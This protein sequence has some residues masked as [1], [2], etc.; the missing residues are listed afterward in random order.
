MAMTFGAAPGGDSPMLLQQG[1]DP[2]K[3]ML[4]QL[5]A[6]NRDMPPART[7]YGAT[8]Q[9]LASALS[10][11]TGG[12]A[13]HRDSAEQEEAGNIVA[14][15]MKG[16]APKEKPGLF[17][18][19]GNSLGLGD[20]AKPAAAAMPA[21]APRANQLASLIAEGGQP[22][23]TPAVGMP[24]S[25][26]P[27]SG[28]T[29]PAA[30]VSPASAPA[31]ARP[32]SQKELLAQALNSSNKYVK[33]WAM[34]RALAEADAQTKRD[35]E[36]DKE[37]A[38][39]GLRRIANADGTF[40]VSPVSGYGQGRGQVQADEYT[41]Q[42]P[43]YLARRQGEADQDIRNKP[44]QAAATITAETPA[45]VAQETAL[46][47]V[48]VGRAGAT[49]AAQEKAALPFVE[50]KATAQAKG[51]TTGTLQ[52]QTAAITP[53]VA[54]RV[55]AGITTMGGAGTAATAGGTQAVTGNQNA[56]S[57]ANVLRDEFDAKSK[58]FRTASDAYNKIRVSAEQPSAAG[59]IALLTGFMRLQDPGS[60]VREGE[61][62]T[63]SNAGS[64]DEKVRNIY[65]KIV[66]GQRLTVEQ[67]NDFL[68][69]SGNA[70]GAY[71]KGFDNL[72]TQYTDLATR[73]NLKPADVVSDYSKGIDLTPVK[74]PARIPVGD[75]PTPPP[76]TLPGQKGA[77]PAPQFTPEQIQAEIARRGLK[78]Q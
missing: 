65:N 38:T 52:A 70:F 60:T 73:N 1:P 11:L 47:P 15:L 37:F 62:A 66:S 29:M 67:R 41:A 54:A 58:D 40:S 10:G 71:K 75:V 45:K 34:N 50:P 30:P 49:T 21:P 28:V 16:E 25:P 56:F 53:D 26:S 8:M 51:N 12:L 33:A 22:D 72:T 4:A 23:Q 20:D 13:A 14:G 39:K 46:T 35:A 36:L 42:S 57:N 19:I 2:Q 78:A 59:D 18:R 17:A 63:A 55:P 27:D 9:S 7:A 64:V 48:M 24:T 6:A 32:A 44:I 68:H 77:A 43:A 74:P 69:Q 3:A 76:I 31:A 61:F 5:L